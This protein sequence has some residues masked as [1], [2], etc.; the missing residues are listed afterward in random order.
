MVAAAITYL[1]D[2]GFTL[3]ADGHRLAVTGPALTDPQRAWLAQHKVAILL[4]LDAEA[5]F[6]ERAA[7]IHEGHTIAVDD[8]G[9]PLIVPICTISRSEAEARARAEVSRHPIVAAALA[10][11]PGATIIAIRDHHDRLNDPH[12][13]DARE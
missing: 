11:W 10:E 9:K 7:I 5:E 4:A 12:N 6:A 8:N 3:A 1:R 2:A 13:P